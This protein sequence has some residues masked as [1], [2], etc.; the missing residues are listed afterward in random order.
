MQQGNQNFMMWHQSYQSYICNTGR[1]NKQGEDGDMHQK[2]EDKEMKAPS[3]DGKSGLNTESDV[4]QQKCK[5]QN[6]K[7][8]ICIPFELDESLSEYSC[9]IV[10]L[11]DLT[12]GDT[13]FWVDRIREKVQRDLPCHEVD[14]RQYMHCIRPQ[15]GREGLCP[16]HEG[17]FWMRFW[18]CRKTGR[19]ADSWIRPR[20]L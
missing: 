10:T 8:Y 12:I 5:I 4:W 9:R 6:G 3:D 17:W 14:E 15:E 19:Q 7:E 20:M 2:S 11:D 16:H 18:W 1:C 13:F